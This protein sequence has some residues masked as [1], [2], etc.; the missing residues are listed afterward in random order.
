MYERLTPEQEEAVRKG[1]AIGSLIGASIMLGVTAL[2]FLGEYHCGVEPLKQEKQVIQ[3][4]NSEK[5]ERAY[6]IKGKEYV[7]T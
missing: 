6:E 2:A 7:L 1:E 4:Q 5:E 3:Y